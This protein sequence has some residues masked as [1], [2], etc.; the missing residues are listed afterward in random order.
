VGMPTTILQRDAIE[1]FPESYDDT[2]HC[3]TF[4]E[5]KLIRRRAQ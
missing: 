3:R 4:R 5:R 2:R 1:R